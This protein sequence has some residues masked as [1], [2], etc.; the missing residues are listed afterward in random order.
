MKTPAS[1]EADSGLR[2]DMEEPEQ[3]RAVPNVN[4]VQCFSVN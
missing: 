2:Q 4:T 1:S 3:A